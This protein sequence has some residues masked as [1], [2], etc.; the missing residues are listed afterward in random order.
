M[1]FLFN[2]IHYVGGKLKFPSRQMKAKVRRGQRQLKSCS[3][4]QGCH[5]SWWITWHYNPKEHLWSVTALHLLICSW[6]TANSVLHS[7]LECL[8]NALLKTQAADICKRESMC[9]TERPCTLILSFSCVGELCCA[10][11]QLERPHPLRKHQMPQWFAVKHQ[12]LKSPN[13]Y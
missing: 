4:L 5:S 10:G 13:R 2:K 1:S 7:S 6:I 11:L 9:A 3:H 12:G 8:T